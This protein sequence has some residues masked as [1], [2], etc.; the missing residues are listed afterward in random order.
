MMTSR[1]VEK[2]RRQKA[3]STHRSLQPCGGKPDLFNKT[4]VAKQQSQKERKRTDRLTVHQL[5]DFGGPDDEDD[6]GCGQQQT[7]IRHED[8]QNQTELIIGKMEEMMFNNRDASI[9]SIKPSLDWL[10]A[11]SHGK[12]SIR[13]QKPEVPAATHRPRRR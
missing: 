5:E 13:P 8:V 2:S 9:P 7:L 11:P 3:S 12:K 1:M 4:A 6:G 10:A